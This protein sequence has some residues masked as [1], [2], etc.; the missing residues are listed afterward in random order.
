MSDASKMAPIDMDMSLDDIDDLPSFGAWPK[1]AAKL[2]YTWE[3]KD[4]GDHKAIE[5]K[6]TCIEVVELGETED[7]LNFPTPKPGDTTNL[8]FM[9]DNEYGLDN[10][11][12]FLTPIRDHFKTDGK[13]RS[14]LDA[15]KGAEI[16]ALVDRRQDKKDPSKHYN[17]IK[18]MAFT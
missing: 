17:S 1:I 11:K 15:G 18:Q 4:I 6:L 14:T 5:V 3:E 10:L 2:S 9:R 12:K 7:A 16:L 13:V 8:L